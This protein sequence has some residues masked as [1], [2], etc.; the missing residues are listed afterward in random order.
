VKDKAQ[1]A[2]LKPLQKVE[3]NL[4]YDGRKYLILEIK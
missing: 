2:G 3:F 4:S 1:L